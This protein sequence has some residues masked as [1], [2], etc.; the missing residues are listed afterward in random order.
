MDRRSDV[1]EFLF[2]EEKLQEQDHVNNS[3]QSEL[4]RI[5]CRAYYHPHEETLYVESKLRP[6]TNLSR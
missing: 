4:G 6:S 1:C 2:F 5:F 3:S